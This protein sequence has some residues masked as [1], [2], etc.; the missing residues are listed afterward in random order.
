MTPKP[1]EAAPVT[2]AGDESPIET[3]KAKL[4]HMGRWERACA[5]CHPNVST[6][7][8]GRNAT[9]L[10]FLEVLNNTL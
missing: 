5:S 2:L 4:I 10:L 1:L 7:V 9:S 3:N 8:A 6:N